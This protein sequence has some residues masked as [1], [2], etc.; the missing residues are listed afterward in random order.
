MYGDLSVHGPNAVLKR[1]LASGQTAIL[2][3]EPTHSVATYSSGVPSA[4]VYVLAAADTPVVGTQKFG[5]ISVKNSLNAAA[6][7]TN[8][9]YLPCACPVPSIGI[10]RGMA[11]TKGSFDTAAEIAALLQYVTLIDYNA[12]GATD[13]G[14]LYTI[15]QSGVAADTSGL[16]IIGGNPTL[17]SVDVV[18]AARAYRS[19]VT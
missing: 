17:G 6:G 12:T 7:T 18:V 3:G 4:T 16:E 9:Q 2:A 15:K 8:A 10:L 14:Q 19:D 13:G 11:E 1:Y 5:G